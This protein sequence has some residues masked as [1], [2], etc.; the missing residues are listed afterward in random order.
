MHK[1]DRAGQETCSGL[2]RECRLLRR[3]DAPDESFEVRDALGDDESGHRF[4]PHRFPEFGQLECRPVDEPEVPGLVIQIVLLGFGVTERMMPRSCPGER[5]NHSRAAVDQDDLVSSFD[6]A[7]GGCPAVTGNDVHA[8]D[9]GYRRT[10]LIANIPEHG[11]VSARPADFDEPVA[12]IFIAEQ[13]VMVRVDTHDL[14]QRPLG[15]RVCQLVERR[16]GVDEDSHCPSG[17]ARE[18]SEESRNFLERG[19]ALQAVDIGIAGHPTEKVDEFVPFLAGPAEE[20]ESVSREVI[21]ALP[22]GADQVQDLVRF[23]RGEHVGLRLA[24]DAFECQPVAAREMQHARVVGLEGLR[25]RPT[26][27]D[28]V[29]KPVQNTRGTHDQLRNPGLV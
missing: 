8:T 19:R 18:S 5:V 2:V 24:P 28:L 29:I 7:Q 3:H 10:L 22:H 14:S 16:F 23:T 26:D 20:D 17:S 13:Q 11:D 1:K 27:A 9:P 25:N 21:A 12:Q 6:R 4:P 15:Q